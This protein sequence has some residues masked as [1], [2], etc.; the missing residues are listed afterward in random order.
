MILN[1]ELD[2]ANEKLKKFES[3]DLILTELKRAKIK[4]PNYPSDL[5]KQV[6]IM[7]E[8]SGEVVKAVLDY[9][10]HKCTKEDIIKE[11]AQ[12]AAMCIRMMDSLK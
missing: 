8:E 11:L 3:L 6:A 1:S 2:R 10:F 12:T 4:H 9:S 7:Q 5:F